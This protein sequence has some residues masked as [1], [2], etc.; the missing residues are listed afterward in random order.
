MIFQHQ[1]EHAM[2]QHM[3]MK[4]IKETLNAVHTYIYLSIQCSPYHLANP[5]SCSKHD[6][7]FI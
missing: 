7:M 6:V 2:T 5:S 1:K 4:G 3:E